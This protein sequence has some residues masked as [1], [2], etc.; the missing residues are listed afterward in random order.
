MVKVAVQFRVAKTHSPSEISRFEVRD[1]APYTAPMMEYDRT[2]HRDFRGNWG[3]YIWRL[4][5]AE[6][7]SYCEA[8]GGPRPY[9][10]DA[11]LPAQRDLEWLTD[12]DARCYRLPV[13]IYKA[14]LHIDI[15][16]GGFWARDVTVESPAFEVR[17]GV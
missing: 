4:E 8:T 2:I 10:A 13:G 17:H 11:S 3:V 1:A 6:W 12:G 9:R 7:S 5:G 16:P 14:T 15:N